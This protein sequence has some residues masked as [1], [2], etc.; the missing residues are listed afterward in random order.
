MLKLNCVQPHSGKKEY[1]LIHKICKGKE[2]NGKGNNK[3][4]KLVLAWKGA[5]NENYEIV[6]THNSTWAN[7]TQKHKLI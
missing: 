2:E 5:F 4:H 6:K 1:F 3:K 7:S